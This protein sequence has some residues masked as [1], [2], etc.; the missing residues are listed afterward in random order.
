MRA[1]KCMLVMLIASA[2]WVSVAAKPSDADVDRYKAS[3]MSFVREEGYMPT[4]DSDGDI[5]FKREGNSY[6]VQVE[7][8]EDGYYVT[9]MTLTG[10][11]GS[12]L[13]K[14]RRAMDEAVRSIKFARQYTTTSEKSVVTSYSWYCTSIADFKK[15]F[16]DAL[17]VVSTADARFIEK[18]VAE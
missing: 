8:Y 16:S 18:M 6:W 9:V 14:V 2:A 7:A 5:S 10:I 3:A 12:N 11:E 13:T 1:L 4:L 17:L 15:M